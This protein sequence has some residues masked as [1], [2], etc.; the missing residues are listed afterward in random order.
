[1]GARGL[2]AWPLVLTAL[3][4]GGA[5]GQD[6]PHPGNDAG[7]TRRS[8]L[9]QIHK[10]NVA[11]LEVAW[12]FDTGDWSDGTVLPSRSA[13]EATPLAIDG[14]LYVPSAFSRLFALDAETG[15]QLWVFDPRIDKS[16]PRN[17]YVNRGVASWTDGKK[18]LVFLG[19][20]E[21]RLWGIDA[22][23]GQPD[24]AFGERGVVNMRAGMA[25]AFPEAQYGLTSPV[26]LCGDVVVA[27]ALVSD[28]APRG[29][30]GDVRGLDARTGRVLWRFHTVPRPGEPGHDTWD[31]DSWRER[32]GTNAWSLLSVDEPRRLVFVPLTSPA[33]D[34][35]GGDRRGENLFGNSLVAL[36]CATGKRRWHFQTVHH[37]V[38]DYDLPAPPVLVSVKRD[39]R[40]VPG[41]AQVTKMGFVF[42]LHRETGE[43]LFPV[44]ERPVAQSALEG[45]FLH[46]T[47]PFPVKPPPLARIAMTPD[48][49]TD[50]T[51]QSRRE[52]EAVTEGADLDVR[53]YDP[54]GEQNQAL[55][56]GL[57][58]GA[59]YG[60]ASF[61]PETH[62]LFVN[63]MDVGG[64]FRMSKR[65]EESEVPYALRGAKYEFFW[66]EN[67]YPCQ[68]PP[69]GH[70]TAV[71]LDSGDFRWRVT[72]GEFEELTRRGVPKT[73]TPNIGGSIVTAGGLVFVA[74]T[75]DHRFRAFDRDTGR[76]LWSA[77]LPA[78]GFA[79]PTTY[80]G[81]RTGR[82]FVVIPAGGG[83]KYDSTFSGEIVAFALPPTSAE[84]KDAAE[85][86][87]DGPPP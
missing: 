69:W 70:L 33:Y 55:F 13:F 74:A 11:R 79:T 18:R 35:Y 4:G 77:P 56:P 46:P 36:E 64:L 60:G 73:G 32:G 10:G 63:T 66:D 83:N 2:A 9:D 12:T 7:G 85:R 17:L 84:P 65:R 51:P 67:R 24:P 6:W 38:W 29:P 50:V 68:K 76:E 54:L 81:R 28:G 14:V 57:N 71:D 26:A 21:G 52:C 44:E 23:T 31:G 53:I 19:D 16:V 15:R 59:N 1:M 30:S 82:Q 3:G 27:G 61:D 78:S 80:L 8:P 25:D 41:V 86:S 20:I 48:E 42:V 22:A 75:S 58:G 62:L 5:V 39:G 72:L 40:D 49:L 34:F 45:E 47:Q 87:S 43:P 37:D